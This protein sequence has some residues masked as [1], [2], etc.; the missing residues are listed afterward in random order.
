MKFFKAIAKIITKINEIIATIGAYLIFPIIAIIAIEVIFRYF[1][2][3]P[4]VWAYDMTWMLYGCL[5]FMGGAYALAA[6][7]HVK[8][9]IFYNL[10][11]KAGQLIINLI[12][13]PAFFFF[14]MSAFVYSSFNLMKNAWVFQEVSRYTMWGAVTWPCKTVLFVSFTLLT[15]QG[16]IK[17]IQ[18]IKEGVTRE[19]VEKAK[20]IEGGEAA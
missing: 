10:L 4:T 11:P 6:N 7:V 9:D 13:Y 16:V 14:S 18:L 19:K 3:K 12:C 8:A 17:F 1:I 15:I 20:E 2:N 5:I